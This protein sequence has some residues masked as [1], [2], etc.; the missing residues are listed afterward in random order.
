MVAASTIYGGTFNLLAVT[1]KNWALTVPLWT[2]THLRRKLRMLSVLT[3]RF[4]CGN[5]CQPGPCSSGYRK[6]AS[7]AH[8]HGVPLIVDNTFATPINCRPFEWGADIITHSTTKYMDGHGLQVGGAIIDSG[9]FDWEAYG[10][11]YHGLTQ[12]DESYHGVVY[13]KQ[14]GKKPIS[15]KQPLSL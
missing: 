7:V 10:D 12:P 4:F 9:N 6:F 3:P 11:K 15:P 8:Q 13:T 2:Q 1:F 5:H 14:F